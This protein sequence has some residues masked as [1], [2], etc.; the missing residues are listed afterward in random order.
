MGHF[1]QILRFKVGCC[2][3][4]SVIKV[5][6]IFLFDVASAPLKLRWTFKPRVSIEVNFFLI[7]IFL[8]LISRSCNSLLRYVLLKRYIF[9]ITLSIKCIL[10][11]K[12]FQ[13]VT[14]EVAEP[15]IWVHIFN[16]YCLRLCIFAISLASVYL[17]CFGSTL[18]SR[19]S[20]FYHN[21]LVVWKDFRGLLLCL[22]ILLWKSTICL[23]QGVSLSI[24]KEF[25]L[26]EATPKELVRWSHSNLTS[27]ALLPIN[28]V[29]PNLLTAPHVWTIEEAVFFFC[30]NHVF[31]FLSKQVIAAI[32]AFPLARH[33]VDEL[34][35]FFW[36]GRIFLWIPNRIHSS[37][38]ATLL[39]IVEASIDNCSN[40]VLIKGHL[41]RSLIVWHITI[42]CLRIGIFHLFLGFSQREGSFRRNG[43]GVG[44]WI[45]IIY[46]PVLFMY[47]D[48]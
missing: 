26:Y 39:S 23:K 44:N 36:Y 43:I 31:Q 8:D 13:R 2:R 3:F 20:L 21:E 45:I 9:L 33:R 10:I 19:T 15:I 12:P 46:N 6:I 41:T 30:F 18:W 35:R 28:W 34:D 38:C 5:I 42:F 22:K 32:F 11:I 16:F 40:F 14:C 27:L 37:T 4:Y 48:I 24:T 1:L 25:L 29:N 7:L 17:M 47:Y